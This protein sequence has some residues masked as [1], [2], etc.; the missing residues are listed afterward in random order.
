MPIYEYECESCKKRLEIMQKMSDPALEKC[1]HC[2]GKLRKLISPSGLVFKGSGWYVTDYSQKL[3]KP[4]D[5]SK[6]SEAAK[7][8]NDSKP[9]PAPTS[10]DG[11]K[12]APSDTP[13]K[14]E[15]PAKK[16]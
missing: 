11:N 15:S 1:E 14:K 3:K 9:K 8:T 2:L 7:P 10:G 12:K 4:P 16:D 5:E 6:P 13:K